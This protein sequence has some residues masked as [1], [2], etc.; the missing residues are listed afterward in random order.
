MNQRLILYMERT[1]V[2]E[3]RAPV[4]LTNSSFKDSKI[5]LGIEFR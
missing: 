4:N 2:V 3:I 1:P 5:I